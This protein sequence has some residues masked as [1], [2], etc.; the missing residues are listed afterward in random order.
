YWTEN[1]RGSR[2]TVVALVDGAVAG[3]TNLLWRSGYKPFRE[4]AIPEIN[5][6]NVLEPYRRRGIATALIRACEDHARGAGK[7]VMGIGVGVPADYDAA[8]RL[9]PKLGYA[10]DGRGVTPDAWGGAEY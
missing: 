9:Y 6:L 5:D 4:E 1:E 3:Y 2:V 8:R 10:Y 7:G